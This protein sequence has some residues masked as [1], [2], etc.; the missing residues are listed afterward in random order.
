MAN[1][2]LQSPQVLVGR[3]RALL[4]REGKASMPE[5]AAFERE[6]LVAD[7]E[8]ALKSL[9]PETLA[10][11]AG[12]MKELSELAKENRYSAKWNRLRFQLSSLGK[13]KPDRHAKHKIDLIS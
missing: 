1:S 5:A 13:P 11:D 7:L 9:R 12:L 4:K 8:T 6:K 3:L 2:T 10:A